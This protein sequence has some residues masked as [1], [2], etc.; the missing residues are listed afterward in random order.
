MLFEDISKAANKS[1]DKSSETKAAKSS[2]NRQKQK[3]SDA[4]IS[5]L[6][7]GMAHVSGFA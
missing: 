6:Q 2:K 7:C 3:S 5:V 4:H 1:S